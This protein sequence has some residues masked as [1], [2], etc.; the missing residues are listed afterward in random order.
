M[1]KARKYASIGD[2]VK[3]VTPNRF[4]RCGYELTHDILCDQHGDEVFA[5]AD[6]LYALL[7]SLPPKPIVALPGVTLNIGASNQD[8]Y[9]KDQRVYNYLTTAVCSKMLRDLNWGGK[10]RKIFEE[11]IEAYRLRTKEPWKVEAKRLVKTGTRYGPRVHRNWEGEEDYEPGG[12][13]GGKTHCVY[14]ISSDG[15][16]LNILA[17]NCEVSS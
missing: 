10:D 5:L 15:D 13:D 2:A 3:I 14:T 8:R 11:P 17:S 9:K 7:Y 4:I 6:K 16:Q 1:A 12:L